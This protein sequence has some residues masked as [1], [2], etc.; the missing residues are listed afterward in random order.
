MVQRGRK[1]AQARA[2]KV[3]RWA[4]EKRADLE[5]R[6]Y[7]KRHP[8]VAPDPE[9]KDREDD[10]YQQAEAAVRL[11]RDIEFAEEMI[12][13]GDTETQRHFRGQ[14]QAIKADFKRSLPLLIQCFERDIKGRSVSDVIE[15]AET[16]IE[17]LATHFKAAVPR[18][19][20]PEDALLD[21]HAAMLG[22]PNPSLD[23]PE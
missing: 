13:G 5:V 6:H 21:L 16:M 14:K 2:E 15:A 3:K 8:S 11:L 10:F 22:Q 18:V 23:D 7:L 1:R 19:I 12:A 17:S 20:H 4:Q 9:V